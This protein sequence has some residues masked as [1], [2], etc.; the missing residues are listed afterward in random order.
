[1]SVVTNLVNVVKKLW[2]TEPTRVISAVTGVVVFVAANFG[3]VVQEANV[4][5]AVAAL[6]VILLGGEVTR[7]KVAPAK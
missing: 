5:T 1:M 4:T 6:L 7:S 3:L 2:A